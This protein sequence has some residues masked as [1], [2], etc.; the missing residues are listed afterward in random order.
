MTNE[1]ITEVELQFHYF[2]RSVDVKV[3]HVQLSGLQCFYTGNLLH[4]SQAL[5]QF[6]LILLLTSETHTMC[7]SELV[8]G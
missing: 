7:E 6:K 1:P 3:T 8:T 4:L 5:W 2:K